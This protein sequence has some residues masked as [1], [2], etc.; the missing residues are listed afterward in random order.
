MKYPPN[1]TWRLNESELNEMLWS[2][3]Y[4]KYSKSAKE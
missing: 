3:I 4:R 1:V 2:L